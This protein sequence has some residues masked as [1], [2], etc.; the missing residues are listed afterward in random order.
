[1]ENGKL[2]KYKDSDLVIC[3]NC[4]YVNIARLW[5]NNK[6]KCIQCGSYALRK[7]KLSLSERIARREAKNEKIK[8]ERASD[9][10]KKKSKVEK[11]QKEKRKTSERSKIRKAK[12]KKVKKEK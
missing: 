2:H 12:K 4:G 10:A 11:K 3:I 8:K 5:K 1:M 9:D 7:W 6:K